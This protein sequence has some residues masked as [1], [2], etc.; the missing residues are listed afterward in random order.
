MGR[1][2]GRPGDGTPARHERGADGQGARTAR[3]DGG[4]R[5]ERGSGEGNDS[6]HVRGGRS[7]A[8]GERGRLSTEPVERG[9]TVRDVVHTGI[10]QSESVIA[11]GDHRREEWG[12]RTVDGAERESGGARG[13]AEKRAGRERG[14]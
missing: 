3:E 13:G 2:G 6:V 4:A 5:D 1:L 11:V 14:F 9:R 10:F 7:V 8:G 12:G